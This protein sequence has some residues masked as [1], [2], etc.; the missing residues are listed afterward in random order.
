VP[1]VAIFTKAKRMIAPTR[2]EGF[3]ELYRVAIREDGGFDVSA[4]P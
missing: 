3:D 1:D 2:A 4:V